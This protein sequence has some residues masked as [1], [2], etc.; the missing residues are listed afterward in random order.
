MLPALFIHM[1]G[2]HGHTQRRVVRHPQKIKIRCAKPTFGLRSP[3]ADVAGGCTQRETRL[4]VASRGAG[5]RT[6][7]TGGGPKVGHRRGNIGVQ[8]WAAHSTAKPR[9]HRSINR[10]IELQT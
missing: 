3:V 1:A 4:T 9:G 7:E 10:A 5:L 8:R 6:T 2:T